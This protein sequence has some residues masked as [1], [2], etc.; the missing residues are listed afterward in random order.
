MVIQKALSFQIF[1]REV[2]WDNQLNNS[3]LP[4]DKSF[5]ISF[6]CSSEMLDA[7]AQ[8]AAIHLFFFPEIDLFFTYQNE[9]LKG[10]D[11][12]L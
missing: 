2:S 7:Q 10:V 8:T 9:T 11:V 12:A 1:S 4:E 6:P 5:F 3:L